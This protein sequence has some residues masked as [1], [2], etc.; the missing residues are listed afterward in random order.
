MSAPK[1][2]SKGSAKRKVDG[3]NDRPPKMAAVIPGDAHPKKKSP[4]KLSRGTGKGMMTSI[5]PVVEGPCHLF[6]HKDYAIEEVGSL[7]KLMDME[8]CVEL[9]TKELRVSTLFDLT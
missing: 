3:K 9:G 6:T 1:V 5:G 2:V 8:P 7:V 4:L